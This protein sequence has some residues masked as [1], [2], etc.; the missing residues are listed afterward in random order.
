MLD[1]P[2]PGIASV[3]SPSTFAAVARHRAHRPPGD[4]TCRSDLLDAFPPRP[5]QT[6][7]LL[8]TTPYRKANATSFQHR[9]GR[10][11]LLHREPPALAAS[12]SLQSLFTTIPRSAQSCC[13]SCCCCCCCCLSPAARSCLVR[14][15]LLL[16]AFTLTNIHQRHPLRFRRPTL[17][18]RNSDTV[19]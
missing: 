15:C 2:P 1:W 14:P 7:P 3:A 10:N 4:Q 16:L 9:G 12:P 8:L 11:G 18:R 13:C 5:P 19:P 6:R 17:D